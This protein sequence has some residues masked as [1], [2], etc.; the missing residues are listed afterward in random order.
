MSL[1]NYHISHA[2]ESNLQGLHGEGVHVAMKPLITADFWIYR[3]LE[4][5]PAEL[6]P[7]AQQVPGALLYQL[8]WALVVLG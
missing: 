2:N 5:R 6:L 7:A 8:K 3:I 1:L 4:A